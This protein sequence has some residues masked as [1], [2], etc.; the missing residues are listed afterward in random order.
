MRNSDRKVM[1]ELELVDN[2]VNSMLS[3]LFKNLPQFG[4][5]LRYVL[6]LMSER[7]LLEVKLG[8]IAILE[9]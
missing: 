4:L 3:S 9:Q 1:E 2:V 7:E 5:P 6:S 8:W